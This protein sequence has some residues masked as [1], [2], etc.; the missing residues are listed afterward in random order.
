MIIYT[1]GHE[2]TVTSV[3]K[4]TD[5]YDCY[6]CGDS[7]NGG[8]CRILSLKDKTVF[9]ELVGWLSKT[10]DP[11]VFTDYKE[12]FIFEDTLCIVMKYTQGVSLA[13]KSDTE[14]MSLK[15]R[16]EL[17]RRI[18]ER[19]VLLDIPDYF[20]EKCFDA[21][22]IIV[23]PDLT[24]SFNYPIEDIT[25]QRECAPMK[26]AEMF[27]RQLFANEIERKVPDELIKFFGEM[28]GLAGSNM[29]ELYSKYY[30]MMNSVIEREAGDEEPKSIWYRIWNR[31]KKIWA[32]L[33]KVLMLLL[34]AAAVF[35]LVFTIQTSGPSKKRQ[36]TFESIGTL[37]IDKNM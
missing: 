6:I 18:L 10:V 13:N 15:E 8:F 29:I 28:P 7:T 19:T 9:P 11:S 12:H 36:T 27:L 5:K 33:K 2:Y 22:N 25:E 14:A 37:T 21:H 35:Y 30:M 24:V 16:L 20:L 4:S 3:Q 32:K 34:L 23:S 1:Y 26:K 17:G 31:I